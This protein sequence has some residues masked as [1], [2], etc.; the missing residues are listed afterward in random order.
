MIVYTKEKSERLYSTPR[1]EDTWYPS[2]GGQR[3]RPFNLRQEDISIE[4]AARAASNMGRFNG[5][6]NQFYSVAQSAVMFS[7]LA[8]IDGMSRLFVQT[9][10][11]EP[12][13]QAYFYVT[14]F[15][16]IVVP[17]LHESLSM[18]IKRAI[19]KKVGLQTIL[20][21]S[22]ELEMLKGKM[23][24][25]EVRDLLR[26]LPEHLIYAHGMKPPPVTLPEF[27]IN[28]VSPQR[29]YE[30]YAER[31]LHLFPEHRLSTCF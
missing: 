14:R 22:P 7:H 11:L 15:T 3:Y 31:F 13:N 18:P 30:I 28:P 26:E 5:H 23:L 9:A 27:A 16:E 29:A 1:A 24:R 20:L 21:D 12:L 19:F 10:L 6:T 17:W 25:W 4:Y 8:E 2:M